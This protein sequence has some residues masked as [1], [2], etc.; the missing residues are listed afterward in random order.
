M[1]LID[2]VGHM[3]S[4]KS[5]NELHEFAVQLGLKHEWYQNVGADSRHPHYDLTTARMRRKAVRSG[6]VKVSATELF[7]RAWWNER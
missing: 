6:A 2:N 4:T 7:S 5:E 3:I 1:I